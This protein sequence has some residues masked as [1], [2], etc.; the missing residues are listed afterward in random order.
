MPAKS[1]IV[2]DITSGRAM[3]T[4]EPYVRHVRVLLSPLLQEGLENFAVGVTEVPPG[5]QGSRHNHPDACEVWL[6]FEGTGKAIVGGVEYETRPGV[7]IYTPPGIY[8][9]F[10]NTGETAVKLYYVFAPSG[11]E[12][13]VIDGLFR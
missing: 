4:P 6:F 13:T 11:P 1:Q 12:K 7:V 8:H 10:I 9:Q 2:T 3:T 5:Q